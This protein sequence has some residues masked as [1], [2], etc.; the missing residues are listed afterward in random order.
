MMYIFKAIRSNKCETLQLLTLA[1]NTSAATSY[2][3]KFSD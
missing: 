3:Y 2:H 1:F